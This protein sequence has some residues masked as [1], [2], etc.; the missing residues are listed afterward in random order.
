MVRILLF[1]DLMGRWLPVTIRSMNLLVPSGVPGEGRCLP[2]GGQN[3][4]SRDWLAF[5]MRT[6][7][8]CSL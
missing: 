1:Q 4:R 5:L 6:L 7:S 8:C 2:R 3:A